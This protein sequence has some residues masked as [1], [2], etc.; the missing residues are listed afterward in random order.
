[1]EDLIRNGQI[2]KM[3]TDISALDFILTI[4]TILAVISFIVAV[5]IKAYKVMEK[6]RKLKNESEKKEEKFEN[7]EKSIKILTEMSEQQKDDISR[8]DEKINTVFAMLIEL[9]KHDDSNKRANLKDRISQSYRY[10]HSTRTITRMDIETLEGLIASYESC[11]GTN[12]FVH[13]V[14]QKEMY[15]WEIVENEDIDKEISSKI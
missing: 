11:G 2:R 3:L 9:R 5:S 14:V 4:I 8:L 12:S 10:H 13:E 6:Y 15:T 7:Y 1:M